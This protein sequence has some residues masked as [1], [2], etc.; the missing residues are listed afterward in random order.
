MLSASLCAF[1]KLLMPPTEWSVDS[2]DSQICKW[3]TSGR[4][5]KNPTKHFL[6][7]L[8]IYGGLGI[9]VYV[10]DHVEGYATGEPQVK[11]LLFTF[12][13]SHGADTFFQCD[14]RGTR[15]DKRKKVAKSK[16]Y[17]MSFGYHSHQLH[18][19]LACLLSLYS[20]MIS[21]LAPPLKY[22]L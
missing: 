3:K 16:F 13:F 20:F 17:F 19:F 7:V 8:K 15:Q 9:D 21:L 14:L 22:S 1:R 10:N 18:L 4:T 12:T 6:N 2:G 5:N 11:F